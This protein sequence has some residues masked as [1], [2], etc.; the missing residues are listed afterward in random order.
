SD[1]SEQMEEAGKPYD[2]SQQQDFLAAAG[3]LG[4]LAGEIETWRKQT[5]PDTVYWIE[6]SE[7]RRPQTVLAAA[8]IDVGRVLREELFAKVPTVVLTSATLSVGAGSF[9]FLKSRLVLDQDALGD[10]P[11]R[12]DA[13]LL[14]ESGHLKVGRLKVDAL[15]LGSPFNYEEQAELVL[16]R[17]MP[18]PGE[19]PSE[20]EGKVIELVRRY[21]AQ[22]QG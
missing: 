2:E 18:D 3:R 20:F 4:A 9:D 19:Q 17:D 21:V 11:P 12:G 6:R 10:T 7:G 1:L 5:L 16:L 13:R 14:P 22:G 15:R 8:P